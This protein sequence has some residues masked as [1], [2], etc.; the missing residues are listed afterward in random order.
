MI[1]YG[2][3]GKGNFLGLAHMMQ[4]LTDNGGQ[5]NWLGS[6]KTALAAMIIMSL[7]GIGGGMVVLLAGLQGIPEYYYEAAMLDGASAWQKFKAVTVPLLTPSLFFVLVTGVI[8]SFQVFTQTFVMTQGGPGDATR[9]YMLYLYDQAF[10]SLRMGY[11]S[12]LAWLLF[13]II[14]IATFLQFKVNKWVHSEGV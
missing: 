11:A 10:T 4:P 14:A 1:I 9:F 6:D 3:D 2:A 12:A 13:L 7:W 8:G 5:V